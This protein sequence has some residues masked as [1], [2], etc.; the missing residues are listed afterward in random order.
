[1]PTTV[2]VTGATGFLGGALAAHLLATRPDHHLICL[3]RAARGVEPRERVLRS[4]RRFGDPVETSLAGRLEIMIGDLGDLRTIAALPFTRITHVVHLALDA[5]SSAQAPAVNLDGTLA[6]ARGS[7]GGGRLERFLYVGSAWSCGIGARGVVREDDEPQPEPVSDYLL[8]KAAAERLLEGV[9]RLPLVIARP[10]LVVG[11]TRLGCEPSASLFW[12]IRLL[13]HA[14]RLPWEKRH[15]LDVVPVDWVAS[16]LD[17][18][19]FKPA[20]AHPCYHLSAGAT[21]SASWADIESAFERADGRPRRYDAAPTSL[22]AWKSH[23][24]AHAA[25]GTALP[26]TTLLACL[27]FLGSDAVFDD[28]RARELGIPAAP[29][30]IDYLEIC[31]RR[32]RGRAIAAQALDDV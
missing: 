16:A 29:R 10:S 15:R 18:L 11:H 32:A 1:L 17:H 30:L 27:R 23:V 24:M 14:G 2:L 12:L 19:L 25:S 5:G 13:D 7:Q 28:T 22:A 26:E 6:L 3:A 4:L 9:R 8:H 31:L 20:L 21:G